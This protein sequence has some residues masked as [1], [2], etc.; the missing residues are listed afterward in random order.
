MKWTYSFAHW[1]CT[2][3][4][5]PLTTQAISYCFGSELELSALFKIYP[6]FLSYSLVFSLPCFLVYL[7][8]FFLLSKSRVP[9]IA[10]K[11]ILITISIA[12]ILATI[13]IVTPNTPY[14]ITIGYSIT[15]L[16][17]GLSLNLSSGDISAK[18]QGIFH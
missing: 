3:L 9:L 4:V 12:G 14:E 18:Q 13:I 16:I 15:S 11:L 5:A 10:S 17:V 1:L 2:V 7:L 8:T 6:I